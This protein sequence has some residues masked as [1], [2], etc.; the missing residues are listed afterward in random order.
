LSNTSDTPNAGPSLAKVQIALGPY[1]IESIK[2][3]LKS[4]RLPYSAASR[5]DIAQRVHQ[6]IEKGK[7]KFDELLA[8]LVGI[9][10]SA[11]KHIYLYTVEPDKNIAHVLQKQLV[12][13]KTPLSGSRLPA[14]SVTKTP[15]LIYAINT[16]KEF[17]AKWAETQTRVTLDMK[18][19][20]PKKVPL[21]RIV[22]F[23]LDKQ[24]GHAQL[25]YDTPLQQHSHTFGNEPKAQAYFDFYREKAENMTGF[26]L[27]SRDLREHL[28]ALLFEQPPPVIPVVVST[29]AED[30]GTTTFGMRRKGA[31]PRQAKD[32]KEATDSQ[33]RTYERAPIKWV[34]ELTNQKLVRELRCDVEAA[35]GI[36]RF[37]ADCNENEVTYVLSRFA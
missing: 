25:R 20:E 30:G 21:P 37:D 19:L 8:A 32:W 5:T 4:K 10:E 9:E 29:I 34:Y 31:D 27:K 24:T 28:R 18:T 11:S 3:W 33:P 15:K 35:D 23:V 13:L 7:L 22:V 26:A 2:T 12:D 6:L 14:S 17:R 36:I 16:Q 1:S